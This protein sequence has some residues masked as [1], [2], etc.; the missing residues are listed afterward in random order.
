[1]APIVALLRIRPKGPGFIE[2]KDA[3]PPENIHVVKVFYA[4]LDHEPKDITELIHVATDTRSPLLLTFGEETGASGS[5]WP[6]AGRSSGKGKPGPWGRS[7]P[8][9][10]LDKYRRPWCNSQCTRYIAIC[11]GGR[12][13]NLLC[14][15]PGAIPGPFFLFNAAGAA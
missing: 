11:P 8:V 3:G 9:L 12:V 7:F 10:S 4:I 6:A 5:T 2:N 1:V 14:L 15:G 13:A